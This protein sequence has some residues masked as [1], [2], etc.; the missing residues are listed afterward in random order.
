MFSMAEPDL[1][2][3]IESTLAAMRRRI[4]VVKVVEWNTK[5]AWIEDNTE[6]PL[7]FF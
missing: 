4:Y 3:K 2:Q 6:R 5:T 1:A 7:P